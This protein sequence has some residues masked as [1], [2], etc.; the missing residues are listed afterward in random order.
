VVSQ[1]A[2]VKMKLIGVMDTFGE[3]GKPAE[4]MEKYGLTSK[5]IYEEVKSL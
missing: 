5:H 1:N 2:P 4:L 3:S